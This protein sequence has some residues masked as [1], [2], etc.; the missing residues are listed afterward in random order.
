MSPLR[1]FFT[2][3]ISFKVLLIVFKCL[4]DLAPTALKNVLTIKTPDTMLL[5][6]NY[7]PETN[8]VLDWTLAVSRAFIDVRIF[9]PQAQSNWN[10][11]IPAMYRGFAL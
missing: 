7:F 2:R 8:L 5:Q 3:R 9:N 10:K 1:G 11:S 6:I 4:N